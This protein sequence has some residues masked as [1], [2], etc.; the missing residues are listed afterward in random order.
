MPI[1]T[2][3]SVCRMLEYSSYRWNTAP[4]SAVALMD[5]EAVFIGVT[6]PAVHAAV[7]FLSG[8]AAQVYV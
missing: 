8:V 4:G 1:C 3:H 7:R 5:V 2:M 6:F